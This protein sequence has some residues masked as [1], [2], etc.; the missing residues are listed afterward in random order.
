MLYRFP[1]KIPLNMHLDLAQGFRASP[2]TPITQALSIQTTDHLG[3]DVTCGTPQQTWGKDCV[4]PFPFP[5]AVYDA[6]VDS[7]FNAQLHAHSQID[8]TDPITNIQYS[9]IYIHLSA[10][11]ATKAPG[12]NRQI[13]YNQ[14]DVIGRIGNNGFVN[15][16]PTAARPFDGSHLHLGVGV[17]HVGDLNYF[18]D[19][20]L[21]YFNLSDPF[22]T[23]IA[24]LQFM[25]NLS[26]GQTSVDIQN[27]QSVLQREGFFP[28]TQAVTGYYGPL[29][30]SGV[31]QFRVKYGVSSAND[32]K[33][34]SVGPLTRLALNNL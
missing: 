13:T 7:P 12:D 31:L 30:A 21:K 15:P 26:F 34:W 6:Q 10:V 9:L 16:A 29:T 8:G 25:V 28:A 17:K 11:T 18:M 4:W 14:G 24:P 1:I 23:T 32:P 3:V 22:R 2:T 27:L 5:G 19:D 33:G 20:P